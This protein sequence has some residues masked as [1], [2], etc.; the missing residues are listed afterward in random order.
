[1]ILI[2]LLIDLESEHEHGIWNPYD[3]RL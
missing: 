2:L 3:P 1:M